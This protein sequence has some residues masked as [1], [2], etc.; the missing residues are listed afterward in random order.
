MFRRSHLTVYDKLASNASGV[1]YRLFL[2]RPTPG[3]FT[4]YALIY[5]L[6]QRLRKGYCRRFP[7]GHSNCCCW[8]RRSGSGLSIGQCRIRSHR[9]LVDIVRSVALATTVD[10]TDESGTPAETGQQH[11]PNGQG[12]NAFQRHVAVGKGGEAGDVGVDLGIAFAIEIGVVVVVVVVFV[13]SHRTVLTA[14]ADTGTA[15]IG[16]EGLLGL[17]VKDE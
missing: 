10:T 7:T 2:G 16:C 14:L 6:T 12:E 3:R 15:L 5:L 9:L 17:A 8:R 11:G 4:P 1:V 13:R